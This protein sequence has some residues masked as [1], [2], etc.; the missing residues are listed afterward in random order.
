[1]KSLTVMAWDTA[2]PWCVVGLERFEA[3][4]R[5]SRLGCYQSQEAGTHSQTLPGAAA[6]LLQEAG[7]M[8]AD[9]DLLAVGR[10]PGSFTGLRIGLAL[11]KGLALGAGLPLLGLDSLTVIA[12]AA[13][14]DSGAPLAAPLIDARHQQ[15]FTG[16]YQPDP[17]SPQAAPPLALIEPRPVNPAELPELLLAAAG[18]REIF[19]AGPALDLLSEA[20]PSGLPK[21]L[22]AA[23][24]PAPP[25][26]FELTGLAR[27]LWLTEA[28]AQADYPALPLYIRQPD[29]R[30][31][32]LV[33]K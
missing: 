21:P 15:L 9:L 26:P 12:S 29:I 31:S 32:G 17:R 2:T 10:G 1:M 30:K 11:A 22:T 27:Q 23:S 5:R 8:P 24:A 4:G 7:L 28:E 13:L 19:L 14:K 18:G 3:D 20:F 6:A 33:L 16:L 25:E